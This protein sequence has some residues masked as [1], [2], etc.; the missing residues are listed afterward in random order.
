MQHLGVL[1]HGVGLVLQS[2]APHESQATLHIANATKA[3]HHQGTEREL[4]DAKC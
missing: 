2:S 1:Q 3:P 4:R